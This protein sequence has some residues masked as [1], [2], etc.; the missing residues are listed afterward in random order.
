M[1]KITETELLNELSRAL[2]LV[3]E[4]LSLGSSS[5]TVEEW[6]SLG[7]IAI[8]STLDRLFDDIS[9]RRPDLLECVAMADLMVILE[10]EQVVIRT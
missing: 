4:V 8:L 3:E 7:Q 1:R 6:D 9:D 2:G 5:D 10:S